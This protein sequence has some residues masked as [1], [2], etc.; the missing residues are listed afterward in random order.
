MK[1]ATSAEGLLYTFTYDVYGNNTKVEIT[2][3]GLTISSEAAYTE[4][5]NRIASVTDA[6][7]KIT[8]YSY[9]ENTNVLEWVQY[10]EDS[11]TSRTNYTYDAM[12]RASQVTSVLSSDTALTVSYG[13][14]GDYLT[15]MT[16]G[17][18][19]YSFTYGTFGLRSAVKIGS[20][21]LAEYT[22]TSDRNFYLAQLKYGN[23]DTVTYTYDDLG[24]V[25]RETFE[26]G[27]TVTYAYDNTGALATVTD[28][29]TGRTTS[30]YYDF[31]D[32]L[33]KYAENGLDYSHSVG[34]TYDNINNLTAMVETINGI[35][36]TTSY[37]YD[38]D[39]RVTSVSTDGVSRSY[40]YDALGRVSQ[41]VSGTANGNVVTE[42][43]TYTAP[44]AT[45]TSGQIA[46][47]RV[48]GT[49]FD[50]TYTYTYDDNGNIL[51]VSDG[52][53]TTTYVYDAANQLVRE[54][55]QAGNFTHVWTYDDAGNILSRT[56]YAYT[57]GDLGEANDTINYTYGDESWGDLLTAYDGQTISHDNIG[58]PLTDGTWTYTW[59]HG[60]ELSS[61]T[62]GTAT[63]NFQYG[64]DGLR[65]SRT[66][67]TKTYS[68]VYNGGTLSQMT[69]GSDTLTFTYDASGRPLSITLNG[70]TYYY[71]T[72]LQG[73]V[74]AILN[75]S[76]TAVVN[77][78]YDAWGNPLT[79][80]GD[81]ATTLGTL[82]PLRYRG[83]VYDIE[84]GLYYLQSRYYDPEV[85]RF[86]N[87]DA[88]TST[89]Q[90]LL[91]NNMFAYCLNNP[92][93]FSDS[94]GT[95][96]KISLSAQTS[97][98]D[99][100]WRDASPGGG[101]YPAANY[102]HS[103]S[104]GSVEDKFYTVILYKKIINSDL[105]K[106]ITNT[107]EKAV[108]QAEY[109]AFYNGVLVIK[110]DNPWG[111]FSFGFILLNSASGGNPEEGIKTLR[112][113]Y[114]HYLHLRQIGV[115]NYFSHVVVPSF[116]GAA[117]SHLGLLNMNYYDL[118]WEN[119][120]E[121]LGE[122]N[123]DGYSPWAE[124]AGFAYWLFSFI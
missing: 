13:Y 29:A 67:G 34:Y 81:L 98:D 112:H 120:A 64:V 103:V 47:M 48:Q 20:R 23:E 3:S 78:T 21:T 114:G 17:S 62:D 41:R 102:S 84:T 111:S 32:R 69:V 85:G 92:I 90:G 9:N 38:D 104:Y 89:G 53:H 86:L 1:T 121:Q 11:E 97:I 42:T 58:N 116:T 107:D 63:W 76:G 54:N 74:T 37:T 44:S 113:E 59:E 110:S 16:T 25:T 124:D 77:Y 36:R 65:T 83:Y 46:T 26:D 10:P 39:N 108:L 105:Y 7:G 96:A 72:N 57:T 94:G 2:G 18:T 22:Y 33:M 55:N 35:A 73:D 8:R 115:E 93:A 19:T 27:D 106:F 75:S 70:T 28:S 79:V 43:F 24:R 45:A 49:N 123:R 87:A 100:P 101:G 122:V 12:Y 82:N 61:M 31:T 99:A 51:S 91:S 15:S 50:I 60:R 109:F 95:A 14:T 117:M 71:V 119:I 52:T 88:F 6:L 68:Y 66:D 118:P 40:T 30:Y 56:E 80:A 4:D 5:F